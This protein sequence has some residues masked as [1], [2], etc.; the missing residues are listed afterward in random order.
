MKPM[1]EAAITETWSELEVGRI[2][3]LRV[4]RTSG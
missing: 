3:I 1:R 2:A 4:A